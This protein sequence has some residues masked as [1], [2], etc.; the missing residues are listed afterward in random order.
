MPATY[1]AGRPFTGP[2]GG[3]SPNSIG[4]TTRRAGR[5]PIHL[6]YRILEQ[7]F[8]TYVPS[9]GPRCRQTGKAKAPGQKYMRRKERQ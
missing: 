9:F 3:I 6:G 2:K 1:T 8:G 4:R 5:L 7:K